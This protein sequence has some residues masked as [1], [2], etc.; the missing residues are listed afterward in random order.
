LFRLGRAGIADLVLVSLDGLSRELRH[1]VARS[2][3]AGTVS[4]VMRAV[5][6]RLPASE[7]HV[8]RGGLGPISASDSDTV[9][10]RRPGICSRGRSSCMRVGGSMIRDA[11]RRAFR[12]S[13]STRAEPRSGGPSTTMW[14]ARP[15]L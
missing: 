11:V 6:G 2:A 14:E 15:P 5:G 3:R 13:S 10:C 4:M 1:A 12:D 7:R 9:A 8:L